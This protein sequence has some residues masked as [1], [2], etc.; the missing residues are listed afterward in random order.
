MLDEKT[1]KA[2]QKVWCVDAFGNIHNAITN[3]TMVSQRGKKQITYVMM[4]SV[5]GYRS[6][7]GFPI[8]ACYSSR[9]ALLESEKAKADRNVRLYCEEIQSVN[10]LVEFM[11]NNP[12]APAEEYTDYDARKAAAIR[13][14]ELLG[15]KLEV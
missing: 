12:V 4:S 6:S 10:D 9:E 7:Q 2:G 13:A 11:F 14:E 3:E 1:I 5:D 15:L 8:D